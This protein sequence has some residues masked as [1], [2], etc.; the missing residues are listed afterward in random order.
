MLPSEGSIVISQVFGSQTVTSWLLDY[1]IFSCP[2]SSGPGQDFIRLI[3][4]SGSTAATDPIVF[5]DLPSATGCRQDVTVQGYSNSFLDVL[6]GDASPTSAPAGCASEV[7]VFSKDHAM[8]YEQ[9]VSPP[10][11]PGVNK[12]Q[13][14][15]EPMIE[16]D[17]NIWLVR[18]GASTCSSDPDQ[19][20]CWSSDL[21]FA[22]D[23][24]KNNRVGVKFKPHHKDLSGVSAS[25]TTIGTDC[26]T[27][28]GI[29]SSNWYHDGRLNVYYVGGAIGT[30]GRG[31]QCSSAQVRADSNVIFI[32]SNSKVST[33]AHEIGHS[34]G[35]R[36]QHY[37]GSS[38]NVMY[39]GGGAERDTFQLGQVFRM[40]VHPGSMLN[41]N[42]VERWSTNSS[43]CERTGPTRFCEPTQVDGTCPVES[44]G[45]P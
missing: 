6:V 2:I 8:W 21:D 42:C 44:H 23:V 11:T 37:G 33:L 28:V 27:V 39:S 12:H 4:A 14:N 18:T 25:A 32:G 26:S 43:D 29:Q 16:V 45:P 19:P 30:G 36:P 38:N 41:V 1:E 24:F 15:L 22:N 31:W 40:N 7:S 35:L 9:N 10:W 17:V 20:A 34:Y 5:A 3:P 13:V